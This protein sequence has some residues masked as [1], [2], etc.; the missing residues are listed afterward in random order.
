MAL[1]KSN[2]SVLCIDSELSADIILQ[3]I[4]TPFFDT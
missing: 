3:G 4:F 1:L 2:L